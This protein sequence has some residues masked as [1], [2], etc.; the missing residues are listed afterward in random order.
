MNIFKK[1]IR[2]YT[3]WK[4]SFLKSMNRHYFPKSH[5]NDTTIFDKIKEDPEGYESHLNSLANGTGG[6]YKFRTDE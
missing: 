5:N 6:V 4:K 3:K 2:K 1:V